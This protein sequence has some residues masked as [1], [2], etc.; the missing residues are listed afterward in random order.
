MPPLAG[1]RCELCVGAAGRSRVKA[2]H[3]RVPHRRLAYE[4][5]PPLGLRRYRYGRDDPLNEY[6]ELDSP[7][8]VEVEL[9]CVDSLIA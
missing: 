4:V 2:R 9:M 6:G 1:S 5:G 8:R 7:F 3:H